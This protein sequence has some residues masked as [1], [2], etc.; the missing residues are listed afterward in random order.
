[1]N[2]YQS[3]EAELEIALDKDPEYSYAW[4]S[5]A[6]LSY[7][8]GDLNK[9]VLQTIKAIET[10]S[11]NSQAAYNLAFALED[12]K[13]YLQA[14]HWYRQA[15]R[16]DSIC[17]RDSVY[18]PACSALG[19]LYNSLNQP[20]DAILILQRAHKSYPESQYNYLIYKNLGNGF[21]LQEQTDSALKYLLLSREI[22]PQEPETNLFLAR[23]YEEAGI[24]S[25]SIDALQTYIE[26]ETDTGKIKSARDH[27]KEITIKHLQDLIK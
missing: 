26:L 7:K 6:A 17:K 25:K 9:A 22:K 1:M 12:K 14:I 10:D 18:I 20:I 24:M 8:Q 21:L 2:D 3:A 16:I 15:I 27:L 4:S 23:A 19:R 11:G 5:L 13:D